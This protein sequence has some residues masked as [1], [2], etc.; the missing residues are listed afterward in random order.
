MSDQAGRPV[1]AVIFDWGGT[2]TPWHTVDLGEQWRVYARQIHGVPYGSEDVDPADLD[3]AHALADRILAVE[4][5]AWQRGQAEHISAS[6]DDILRLAGVDAD[7]DRAHLALAAY[8]GF[9]EPH[10]WTD[11]QVGP[12]WAGLRERGIRV[13]VLSNTIWS[14]DYHRG[15]FARDGVLDLLDAD[16]YS[17]EIEHVKP[18]PEAFLAAC[19]TVGADPRRAVYVGDRLYEDVH[20]PHR[21]GMRAIWLPHSDLPANQVVEVEDRPDAVVTELSE[22]LAV[23]DRW[24]TVA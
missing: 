10:T 11:P 20:G 19:A 4:A 12:L 18:A 15:L 22:I 14:R 24:S 1:E 17:S 3:R 21:V 5:D 6:I 23:I 8:R 9:W 13:G 7:H 16:V 2:L